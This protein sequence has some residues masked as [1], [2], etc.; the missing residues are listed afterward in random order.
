M[1]RGQEGESFAVPLVAAMLPHR[2]ASRQRCIYLVL[3]CISSERGCARSV[4]RSALKMLRLVSDTAAL[5][6]NWTQPF[7]DKLVVVLKICHAEP[8]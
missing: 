8:V 5:R 7:F 4:S 6:S 2:R 3:V 1:E